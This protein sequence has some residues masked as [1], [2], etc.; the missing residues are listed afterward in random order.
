[1]PLIVA[2][3]KKQRLIRDRP[4]ENQ[5][6]SGLFC[7]HPIHRGHGVICRKP[8]DAS[9]SSFVAK[10]VNGHATR[11][12][13]IRE[14]DLSELWLLHRHK[15]IKLLQANLRYPNGTL[16]AVVPSARGVVDELLKAHGMQPMEIVSQTFY[17]TVKVR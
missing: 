16:A 10:C 3:P 14:I 7:E 9:P 8:L 12:S 5:P 11:L 15:I 17:K 2:M 6:I 1:M 13:V 4:D